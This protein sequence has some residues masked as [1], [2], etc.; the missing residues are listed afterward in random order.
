M[1]VSSLVS[2]RAAG[3]VR[4]VL[5]AG[6]DLQLR[7]GLATA[8]RAARLEVV[9]VANG[10]AAFRSYMHLQG[11]VDLVVAPLHMDEYDGLALARGLATLAPRLPVLLLGGEAIGQPSWSGNVRFLGDQVQGPELLLEA[12]LALAG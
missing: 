9:E 8:L 5:L 3:R 6:V 12:R 4:R 10:F 11:E 1:T 2:E 7:A